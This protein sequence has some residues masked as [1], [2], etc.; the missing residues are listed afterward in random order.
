MK[1]YFFLIL[2]IFACTIPQPKA[3]AKQVDL[4][5]LKPMLIDYFTTLQNL[6]NIQVAV[7]VAP[8][9][10]YQANWDSNITFMRPLPEHLFFWTTLGDTRIRIPTYNPPMMLQGQRAFNTAGQEQPGYM[11]VDGT[12]PTWDN[13]YMVQYRR[14]VTRYCLDLGLMLESN[15]LY[16]ELFKSKMR[17]H[18]YYDKNGMLK[19]KY[20]PMFEQIGLNRF[21]T[22]NLSS[23][24]TEAEI[25]ADIVRENHVE[26]PG[27]WTQDLLNSAVSG[28]P[29]EEVGDAVKI[30]YYLSSDAEITSF[31]NPLADMIDWLLSWG[32]IPGLIFLALAITV[33]WARQK[34][35]A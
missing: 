17:K 11:N 29:E 22:S 7:T 5:P 13:A 27:D 24:R 3:H 26:F 23:E 12:I 9:G 25:L 28:L 19:G 32:W 6:G 4:N 15:T 21:A 8:K 31:N 16:A 10:W 2:L 18:G 34:V 35:Y 20:V 14:W 30:N 33:A 1:R